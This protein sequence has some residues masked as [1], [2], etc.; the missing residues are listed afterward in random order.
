MFVAGMPSQA[1]DLRPSEP[2][3]GGFPLLAIGGQLHEEIVGSCRYFAVSESADA[4]GAS[5]EQT[6]IGSGV[7]GRFE[8]RFEYDDTSVGG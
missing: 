4:S 1:G 6:L 5:V 3:H 8:T 2:L 7:F